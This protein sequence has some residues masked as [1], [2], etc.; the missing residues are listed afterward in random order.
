MTA[1]LDKEIFAGA[2]PAFD[3]RA[4]GAIEVDQ[5]TVPVHCADLA[6]IVRS[7]Q[8]ADRFKDREDLA[9][10]VQQ[11]ERSETRRRGYDRGPGL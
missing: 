11:L 5:E 7:K 3:S 8:T 2:Q 6:D 4:A 1:G 10:L 9:V